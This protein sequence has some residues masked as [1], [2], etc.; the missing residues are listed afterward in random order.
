LQPEQARRFTVPDYF[1]RR[2]GAT[3]SLGA[4]RAR[5][6][7]LSLSPAKQLPYVAVAFSRTLSYT[8]MTQLFWQAQT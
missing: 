3:E 8:G 1:I 5:L 2:M 6:E 7:L 4:I